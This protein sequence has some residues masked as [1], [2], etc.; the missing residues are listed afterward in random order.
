MTISFDPTI[1]LGYYQAKAGIPAASASGTSTAKVAPTAPWTKTETPAQISATVKSAMAGAKLVDENAAKLDLPGASADY[2]KLFALY[3]G[4]DT[5]SGVANQMTTKGLSNSTKTQISSAFSKGLTEIEAYIK[6]AQFD[7]LRL[8]QGAASSTVKSTLGVPTNATITYATTPLTSSTADPVPAFEG[9]VQFNISVKRVNQT[10]DVPIDLTAMGAQPR[11]IGNVINFINQQL[12]DAGVETRFASQRIP[13]QPRT[14]T[15]GTK[16][17]TLAPGPDQWAMQVKVGTSEAVSF[18]APATAGALYVAQKAGDPD[19]D[20]NA[21]TNDG[22][23]QQQLLKFQTD[24]TAVATPPQPEGGANWVDGRVSA[25]T[26]GPEI[27]T[28]HAQTVGPDGSVYILADVTAATSG[29]A[30]QGTQDVALLKYDSAG[31]L[32]YTRTL[33]A[34]AS[35]TG[36][37]LAVSADGTVAVAGSVSGALAGSTDGALNSG[38]TGAYAGAPDSFVTLYD[39]SGQELWTQRRGA[40]QDDEASQVAFGADGSVYVAGRSKSALPGGGDAQG[41][42]DAYVEGFKADASGKVQTLFTQGFG[43]AGADKPAG[44]VVDGNA[45]VT[46]SVE[47][48]HAVLRRFDISSGIP[49]LLSTRDIGDLQGGDIAGLALDGGQ[50]VLAG[51]TANASL[52]GGAVTRAY[53][54]GTD[55]FAMRVSSSLTPGS[56]DKIAYYGGSGDDRASSLAVANGQVWIGGSAGTD[57]PGQDPVGTKDGFIANLDVNTGTIGWSRRITGKDGQAAVSA[58]AVDPKGASVLDRLGLPSGAL[59]PDTSQRITAVSSLRPGDQFTIGVGAAMGTV[60]IDQ[61]DTLDTLAQKIQR[62]SG[63]QAK[64]TVTTVS[65]VKQ[66]SIQPAVASAVL[67]IGAG[68][69]DKDALK[70]LGIP[71]GV[72]RA[73]TTVSGVTKPADGKSQI[74]GLQMASDLNLSSDEQVRH[75]LA[76]IATAQGVIRSAY[77]DLVTAATPK[78][79]LAAQAAAAAASKSGAVP[80]YLTNQISNYQAALDRLTGGSSSGAATTTDT[81]SGGIASLLLG[82][83]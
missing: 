45:L 62:A 71:D 51:T 12:Q 73:T 1:L 43:S 30:I 41:N 4:M 28:V 31:K 14:V 22:V 11:T 49:N 10:Y 25:Q 55:A 78:S 79:Q 19:P 24:T 67:Q 42:W 16:T 18:S 83:G 15:A 75:A 40:R 37:G 8:T 81:S 3:Q 60:T 27:K 50:V 59:A 74:Y 44:L 70:L 34:A 68:K 77:K 58:I 38:T 56:G 76:E 17:I 52:S 9:N 72:V 54:G 65:G 33:G 63:F 80:A 36:L 2:K 53:S 69:S 46:A 47:D 23:I 32:L 61:A 6:S 57:L 39:A 48:G 20:H 35:A 66:L 13:G 64:V 7:N 26:L 29:Q 21:A 82:G 5:L